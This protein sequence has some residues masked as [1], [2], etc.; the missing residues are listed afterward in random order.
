[1]AHLDLQR[2]T[3]AAADTLLGKR[4]ERKIGHNTRLERLGEDRIGVRYHA[5]VIYT[6]TRDGWAIVND[7]GWNTVTT[8]QRV[9]ALLPS[10]FAIYSHRGERSLYRGGHPVAAYVPGLAVH[11]G[12]TSA[13]GTGAVGMAS[14]YSY[15]N[16]PVAPILSSSEV[17]G[18]VAAEVAKATAREVKRAARLLREHPEV[19]GERHHNA[20]AY[21]GRV[22]DCARCRAERDIETAARR[23]ALEAE[24][25]RVSVLLNV[26]APPSNAEVRRLGW[27]LGEHYQSF[28]Q[29]APSMND[30]PATMT[31]PWDCPLRPSRY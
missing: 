9:N 18:I 24:H 21:A 7:G 25:K 6:M 30:K 3:F 14:R 16:G 15:D 8:W 4:S 12:S 5:T 11:V 19:G 31:C 17:D 10:P 26:T 13:G 20:N 27:D 23:V 2:G 28:L 22:H 29:H 1:M